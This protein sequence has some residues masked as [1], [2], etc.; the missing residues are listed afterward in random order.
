MGQSEIIEVLKKHKNPISR[1]EIAIEL[2]ISSC[3]V[4][5]HIQKLLLHNE[6]KCI[7]IDRNQAREYFKDKLPSRRMK[8]YYL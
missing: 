4:S 5:H 3:N 2:N 8:L 7:E 1:R 6:I